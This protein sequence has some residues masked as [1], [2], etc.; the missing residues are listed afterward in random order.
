MLVSEIVRRGGKS[1]LTKNSPSM[2]SKLDCRYSS[3]SQTTSREC[4]G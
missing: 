2:L 4:M 3:N 1:E